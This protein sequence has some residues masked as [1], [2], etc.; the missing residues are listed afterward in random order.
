MARK[1][2]LK[3]LVTP[4]SGIDQSNQSTLIPDGLSPRAQ[5]V[6]YDYGEIA[7]KEG[8]IAFGSTAVTAMPFTE[9]VQGFANY[10]RDDDP[11]ELICVTDTNI[12]I[13]GSGGDNWT[14]INPGVGADLVDS[15]NGGTNKYI[16][17]VDHTSLAID[18]PESGTPANYNAKWLKTS[19]LN[20]TNE[21]W[22]LS[23]AYVDG[24]LSGDTTSFTSFTH[25][26]HSPSV[27]NTLV[28]G[29]YLVINNASDDI[30]LYDGTSVFPLR[31][32]DTG[33]TYVNRQAK[34][35]IYFN[36]TL[37]QIAPT[38]AATGDRSP[39]Q[40]LWSGVGDILDWDATSSA[41]TSGLFILAD[42]PGELVRAE[43]IGD[44]T[45]AIYKS[46]SI[47]QLIP[48]GSTNVYNVSLSVRGSGLI[49]PGAIAVLEDRHIIIN[50]DGF[51]I[52]S[53][54]SSVIPAGRNI[55]R[56][57][58][59]DLD[60]QQT[61][62]IKS[63][64]DRENS[65]VRFYYPSASEG[66]GSNTKVV[67]YDYGENW[68][69]LE[70][71]VGNVTALGAFASIVS[72]TWDSPGAAGD[73]SWGDQTETWQET[74][75]TQGGTVTLFG[76]TSGYTTQLDENEFDELVDGVQQSIVQSHETKDF[77]SA[78]IIGQDYKD[79][80]ILWQGLILDAKGRSLDIEYST[81]EGIS[82]TTIRL[83]QVLTG[84][85]ERYK[86]DFKTTSRK[87]RFRFKNDSPD[88]Y[89]NLRN[90]MGIRFIVRER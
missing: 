89:F 37:I 25:A 42:T 83:G 63:V 6:L 52:Y 32:H 19:Y 54:G 46:D 13:Y 56:E 66:S 21:T 44:N 40:V 70:N 75:S 82:F 1:Q 90:R 47:Y 67:I 74:T 20:D 80:Y 85:Y 73:G 64:V 15:T 31:T 2:Q 4:F 17:Q 68:W 36:S 87:I 77:T 28:A 3:E 30:L 72:R 29:K 8:T 49:A 39:Q 23:T 24:E 5:N 62:R 45:L 12:Y 86:L 18:R 50:K 84:A 57:F 7:P 88:S 51:Y 10:F 35:T 48:S 9:E 41:S 53:G 34:Q 58:I 65:R 59:E 55:W 43:I 26:I 76:N 61:I 22:V 79:R 78:D 38:D 27:A 16:A 71:L 60:L 11:D 81:D 69:S 14:A 33:S